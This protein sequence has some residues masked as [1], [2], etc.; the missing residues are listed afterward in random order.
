MPVIIGFLPIAAEC[1]AMPIIIGLLD[2]AADPIIMRSSPMETNHEGTPVLIGRLDVE[3]K[4][5]IIGLLPLAAFFR[6][7]L[8][9][10][11]VIMGLASLV[12][13]IFF[14]VAAVLVS[15]ACWCS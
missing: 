9:C 5:V 4:H 7:Q 11:L 12:S 1:V 15:A 6:W 10:L 8:A 14:L 13:L 3:A 2:R